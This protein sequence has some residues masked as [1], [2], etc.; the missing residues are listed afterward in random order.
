MVCC[1]TQFAPWQEPNDLYR[2]SGHIRCA[3]AKHSIVLTVQEKKKSI[4]PHFF[5]KE[6]CAIV[7]QRKD[8]NRNI[9]LQ[10]K[11]KWCHIFQKQVFVTE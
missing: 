10:C 7:L 1:R 8:N 3:V 11:K 9:E 4:V 2:A 6:Y 5:T